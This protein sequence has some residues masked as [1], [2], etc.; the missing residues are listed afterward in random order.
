MSADKK[1]DSDGNVGFKGAASEAHSLRMSMENLR[2]RD[3]T[4]GHNRGCQLGSSNVHVQTPDPRANSPNV[5]WDGQ[6]RI[7]ENVG[8]IQD[9]VYNIG[10]VPL[11]EEKTKRQVKLK[12][13]GRNIRWLC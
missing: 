9:E 4:E 13:K 12:K 3:D 8:A 2:I 7:S 11:I 10:G 6:L 5:L 1:S